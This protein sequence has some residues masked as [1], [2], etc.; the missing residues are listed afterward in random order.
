MLM[1]L[2]ILLSENNQLK[3][4]H[5]RW[6]LINDK[7]AIEMGD[8]VHTNDFLAT[9]TW[10][11][12]VAGAVL[13]IVG[14]VRLGYYPCSPSGGG[15]CYNTLDPFDLAVVYAGVVLVLG[16][17]VGYT[18]VMFSSRSKQRKGPSTSGGPPSFSSSES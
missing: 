8:A 18:I 2:D 6:I 5:I 7:D 3:N 13:S 14:Y 11:L 4:P 17:F 12:I 10:V 1:S 9:I 15:L 16:G